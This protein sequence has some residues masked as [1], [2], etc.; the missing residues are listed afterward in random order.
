MKAKAKSEAAKKILST[1]LTSKKLKSSF[2]PETY[3]R[4]KDYVSRVYDL[5]WS[6]KGELVGWVLGNQK[7]AIKAYLHGDKIRTMCNCPVGSR[8]EHGAAIGLVAREKIKD[9]TLIPDMALND[10]RKGLLALGPIPWKNNDEEDRTNES[11][12]ASFLSNELSGLSESDLIN[13]MKSCVARDPKFIRQIIYETA[14]VKLKKRYEK[15]AF[16]TRARNIL[17]DVL[18]KRGVL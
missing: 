17:R 2:G 4:G 11:G 12:T 10:F 16:Q 15:K 9:R 8:C 13:I 18:Q 6:P 7:Y 3:S 1:L 14:V 5:V